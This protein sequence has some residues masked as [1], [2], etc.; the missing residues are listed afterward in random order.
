MLR[1]PRSHKANNFRT[2]ELI[3]SR[4]TEAM[5]Y[6]YDFGFDNMIMYSLS[7]YEDN[8][9]EGNYKVIGNIPDSYFPIDPETGYRY[10]PSVKL[11]AID[12][13]LNEGYLAF[14][15]FKFIARVLTR[16]HHIGQM[17]C[18]IRK[19]MLTILRESNFFT[20]ETTYINI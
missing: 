2:F 7:V 6:M 19:E 20:N 16:S 5:I 1:D 14:Y 11:L 13:L 8:D 4:Q 3:S 9:N 15:D 18:P 12:Y 17:L 10:N